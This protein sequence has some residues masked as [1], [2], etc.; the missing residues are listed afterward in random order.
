MKSE[1]RKKI[2]RLVL[3]IT[4][5]NCNGK[6]LVSDLKCFTESGKWTR[7]SKFS[8]VTLQNVLT[9]FSIARLIFQL[10]WKLLFLLARWEFFESC[11]Q[12][13]TPPA[14]RHC[15]LLYLH[16]STVGERWG[17]YSAHTKVRYEIFLKMVEKVDTRL[18]LAL[19]EDTIS[20]TGTVWHE[21]YLSYQ[22]EFLSA[23]S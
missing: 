22:Q 18:F 19:N 9:R 6:T 7:C 5:K 8:G 2:E 4:S 20:P 3:K 17:L 10:K 23:I 13:C 21:L 14:I 15:G 16:K 12:T 11:V 1:K